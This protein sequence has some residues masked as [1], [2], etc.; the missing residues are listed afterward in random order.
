MTLGESKEHVLKVLW[1]YLY[2]W[3]RYKNS[4]FWW[5]KGTDT[6]TDTQTLLKFNIDDNI[7][8]DV[9]DNYDNDDDDKD[10]ENYHENY[11]DDPHHRR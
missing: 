7:D 4:L 11:A 6:R 3:Q 1:S 5:K 10:K 8:N 9:N 2:F